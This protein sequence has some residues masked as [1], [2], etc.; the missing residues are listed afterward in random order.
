MCRRVVAYQTLAILC[1]AAGRWREGSDTTASSSSSPS[2]RE[3]HSEEAQLA[4]RAQELLRGSLSKPL[5]DYH[6]ALTAAAAA[7]DSSAAGTS[8]S[9]SSK[10]GGLMKRSRNAEAEHKVSAVDLQ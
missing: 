9:S 1:T 3:A 10:G 2:S 6:R 7:G 5:E 4:A 8:S